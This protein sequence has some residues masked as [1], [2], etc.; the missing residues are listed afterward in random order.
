V[1]AEPEV[2]TFQSAG[3]SYHLCTKTQFDQLKDQSPP[4]IVRVNLSPAIVQLKSLGIANI[5]AFDFFTRPNEDN[6]VKALEI[7]KSLKIID[8]NCNL[9][10]VGMK[11][12][13]FPLDPKMTVALLE[14]GN[15]RSKDKEMFGCVEEMLTLTAVIASE[16][17]FLNYKDTKHLIRMKKKIGAKEGDH[18][19][20]LNV[21]KFYHRLHSRNEKQKF[22]N[23]FK[24]NEKSL[25]NAAQ[26]RN[27]LELILRK[28][29][30]NTKKSDNDTEGILRC[31]CTGYFSNAAQRL[32]DGSYLVV[33]SRENVLL[34]PT[35]I[36]NAVHPDWVIFHEIVRSGQTGNF[37]SKGKSFIRNVSEIGVDWLA[38]LAPDYYQD[39][40]AEIA[41]QKHAAEVQALP[42]KP[43]F[44]VPAKPTA[45]VEIGIGIARPKKQESLRDAVLKKPANKRVMISDMDFDS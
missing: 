21:Y 1:L 31:V 41:Q 6:L 18:L 10:E 34:H 15:I 23:E 16:P 30:L 45:S 27:S 44:A 4:E 5:L 42:A 12:N 38:E 37:H 14:S 17:V 24:V 43:E 3:E 33:S 19:T 36:L 8:M 26:L 20:L 40:K 11:V 22:C 7:L 9:T 28:Y 35:S 25:I 39:K 32:P 13:D 2:G 29:G